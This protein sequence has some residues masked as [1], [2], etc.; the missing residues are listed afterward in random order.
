MRSYV[1]VRGESSGVFFGRLTKICGRSVH[2][3]YSRRIWSWRGASCCSQVSQE[4]VGPGSRIC[5]PSPD[6]AVLDAVEIHKCSDGA[7]RQL[8]AWPATRYCEECRQVRDG[9]AHEAGHG[10]AAGIGGDDRGREIAAGRAAGSGDYIGDGDGCPGY[11]PGS[12]DDRGD[13]DSL[14]DYADGAGEDD[15]DVYI[16]HG[17]ACS[18]E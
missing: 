4:G 2:L 1:I 13:D 5:A 11:A 6:M 3:A 17:S 7:A 18:G 9:C 15:G 14:R 10:S 8:Y 16:G 12:G